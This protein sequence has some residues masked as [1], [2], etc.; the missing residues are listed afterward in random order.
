MKQVWNVMMESGGGTKRHFSGPFDTEQE[1]IDEAEYFDWEYIDENNFVWSL[2]VEDEE[3]EE[4]E[5][6][7]SQT[8]DARQFKEYIEK[9][10]DI[11][12]EAKRLIGN[13]L[14]YA[15]RFEGDEQYR[16]LCEL[17]DG[18]IGLSDA[19]IRRISL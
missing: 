2:T 17:L 4:K 3:V 15:S 16:V 9:E 6:E 10:Y 14:A 1:A 8:M 18:T 12:E 5:E 11:S 7:P 13:I 19:E